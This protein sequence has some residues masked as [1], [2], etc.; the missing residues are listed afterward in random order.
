METRDEGWE[1]M[2]MRDELMDMMLHRAFGE[3]IASEV[4]AGVC[5]FFFLTM[6]FGMLGKRKHCSL[7]GDFFFSGEGG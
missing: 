1:A 5:V 2:A 4:G 7:D 6:R 3:T